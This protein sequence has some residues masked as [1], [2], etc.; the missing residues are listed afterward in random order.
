MSTGEERLDYAPEFAL[1][2]GLVMAAAALLYGLLFPTTLAPAT[3]V[4]VV[5]AL[6]FA[7]YAV[8]HADDPASVLP[9]RAVLAAGAVAAPL[10][11]V[12]VALPFE[13]ATGPLAAP[14]PDRLL[15]GLGV[16]LAVAV[17]VVAYAVAHGDVPRRG[18]RPAAALLPVAG[19]GV[20]AA[21]VLVDAP[22][23]GLLDGTTIALAGPAYAAARG[24][25]L[26]F[27]ARRTAMALGVL[28][29]AALAVG[30]VVARAPAALAVAAAV[31][32][33]PALYHALVSDRVARP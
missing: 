6:P 22:L 26:P 21:G 20:V 29:G 25:R 31:A 17:P 9:P 24:V 4:A 2:A 28:A 18:A 11:A 12:A 7:R 32:L 19:L 33:W 3:V 8:V 15:L 10:L 16:A 27:H 13:R 23:V 14:S 1:L 5:V 30:A